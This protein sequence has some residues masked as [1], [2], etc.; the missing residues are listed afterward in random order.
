MDYSASISDEAGASPWGNS[1][2]SSPRPNQSNFAT[3]GAD[4][5]GNPPDSPFPYTPSPGNATPQDQENFGGEH[6]RRPGTASTQSATEVETQDSRTEVGSEARTSAD[7]PGPEL[8]QKS[9]EQGGPP[10]VGGQARQ[11]QQPRK[12]QQPQFRLQAKITGLERTGKKDPILRFDVHTN[13]PRFRTTQYRD[14][15]RFHSE[16]VKL[17]EHLISANPEC[18][19]PTVPPAVTSAG[20]GTDEDEARVKALLQRWFNYVCS[21]EVLMRDDEMVLF[22]ESDF[23]YSPMVKMKQP[24]T[25]VRRKILKQFAPPPDDTPELQE[26]RPIVKLFY[27]GTMDAG[28][29]VDKLVKSRRGLGLAES[30]FGVKLGAMHIQEP[31]QGLANAYRKLG[32]IVQTVGDYHAAQATAEA[33][34]IGDPF[35]YHSQDSFVVKESLTNR[36]ILIREFLQAQENTRSKLNAADRLKA[37]SN[38]RREKVDEAITA[39]DDARQNETYLYQKTTR[40]T[41]NLVQERRKWFARTAAD[42]RL[43]I[44]EYVIREIEAERRALAVL[45]SV[46]P[47]I[48]AIDASGGLSRLGRESHPPVRRASVA[49]SQGPKGDAWSGVPRRTD[50]L[51]RSVSGSLMPGLPEEADGDNGPGAGQNQ[52][53]GAAGGR[54]SLAGVAEEDDEDRVDARNAA[55]RLATSTF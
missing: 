1:P 15:R 33:T 46:R 55:S 50:T 22:V 47:D 28:H 43:S 6:Y 30:D 19:V 35:Q 26:A 31:H 2:G 45:E 32:K 51:N 24:A 11:D 23:G 38:V 13:L 34:T 40:V 44:R 5:S 49:A 10:N 27:L 52:G 25:G 54:A 48:R 16:F 29:K 36:Q 8:P 17:A 37:S 21:N 53:L 14:V 4:P 39:L 20:A 42:L 41:Q 3:L 7:S 12:P 9:Q 18:L